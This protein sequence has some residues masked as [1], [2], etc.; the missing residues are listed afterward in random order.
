MTT[1]ELIAS[2]TSIQ[3]DRDSSDEAQRRGP[4][5]HLYPSIL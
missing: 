3:R 2:V 5:R 4:L 1:M